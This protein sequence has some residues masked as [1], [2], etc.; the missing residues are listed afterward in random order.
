MTAGLPNYQRLHELGKLPKD[1]Q[2]KVPGL[3]ET[4]GLEKRISKIM[5]VLCDD[6]KAKIASTDQPGEKFDA[7]CEVVGCEHVAIGKSKGIAENY[8]RLH[9][10]SHPG[11][12]AGESGSN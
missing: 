10:R 1:M 3:A 5:S 6:C 9:M 8:L 11:A 7:K 2:N 4:S 12:M